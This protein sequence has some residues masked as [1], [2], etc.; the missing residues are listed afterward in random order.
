MSIFS[1]HVSGAVSSEPLGLYFD[2][3]TE[4]FEDPKL[5]KWYQEIG[6]GLSRKTSSSGN[7]GFLDTSDFTFIELPTWLVMLLSAILPIR[8]FILFKRH[9]RHTPYA[10]PK[11]RYDLRATTTGICP[12]CG[13]PF[14]TQH[15]APRTSRERLQKSGAG[16]LQF[17]Q[18]KALDSERSAELVISALDQA[19]ASHAL[20]KFN[21]LFSI[22]VIVLIGVAVILAIFDLPLNWWLIAILAA[23]FMYATYWWRKRACAILTPLI[24]AQLAA[25]AAKMIDKPP[26]ADVVVSTDNIEPVEELK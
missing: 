5:D 9:L 24:D 2:H 22:M 23:A 17:P 14:N 11:C 10:C 3:R 25:E 21:H 7:P 4:E 15:V 20:M 1:A 6:F 19:Y 18:L 16:T 26:P 8:W 12:E 13:T